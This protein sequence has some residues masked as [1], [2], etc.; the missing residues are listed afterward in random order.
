MGFETQPLQAWRQQFEEVLGTVGCWLVEWR[1]ARPVD[2]QWQWKIHAAIRRIRTDADQRACFPPLSTKEE[3]RLV[4]H[5]A[6][7]RVQRARDGAKEAG[8]QVGAPD[9]PSPSPELRAERDARAALA[10]ERLWQREQL[11]W[12]CRGAPMAELQASLMSCLAAMGAEPVGHSMARQT[13][14]KEEVQWTMRFHV[15]M[16]LGSAWQE[17]AHGDSRQEFWWREWD[18]N[19]ERVLQAGMR[20]LHRSVGVGTDEELP[21]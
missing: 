5:K 8:I 3:P 10:A 16:Q 18:A 14:V 11:G 12:P 4:V 15:P 17:E 13:G 6:D 20:P 2:G 1:V 7:E 21:E 9:L 19:V